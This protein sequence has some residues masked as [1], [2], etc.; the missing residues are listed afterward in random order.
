MNEYFPMVIKLKQFFATGKTLSVEFR[1]QQLLGLKQAILKNEENIYQALF[2]DLKKSKE[3]AWITEIGFV[4][5]EINVALKNLDHWAKSKK[6]STNLINLPS[7]SSVH[8]EPIGAVLVIAPWNYPFQLL[9][10]PLVGAIAAGNC[11]VLKPSELA[12]HTSAI[13]HKIIEA[14]FPKEY[15][16]LLEGEGHEVIPNLIHADLVDCVFF[17]GSSKIGKLVYTMAA[18]H[19]L[20]VTLELGGKS[21]CVIDASADIK[22]AAKRVAIA[23]FS[24]C[25]QMCVAPDYLLVHSSVKELFIKEIIHCIKLFF[26][27][28]DSNNYQYGKIINEKHFDRLV[29]F[30]K[31]GNVLHGGN[32]NRETL[33]F[34]PTVLDAVDLNSELMQEEI[35]GPILPIISYSADEEAMLLIKKH[36]NPL[37]FYIFSASS[38][39]QKT[40]L[41]NVPSGGACIN[42][43]SWHLT[44][45]NLPF[46]GRGFSG[47]GKY[48]GQFSFQTFS[49]FKAILKTPTWFDPAFKYPPF[50]G[51]LKWF[52][53][54]LG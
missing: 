31:S 10:A 37:A 23:K 15:V 13:M 27:E 29:G 50:K 48:H 52:K 21:P 34:E 46:G 8:S 45:P 19:L 47:I 43:A 6:V 2:S 11:C 14:A 35:F 12:P 1:K 42:N 51:K 39:S 4:L 16:L 49:H 54:I 17:T 44:N 53:K 9:F 7:S 33:Y 3:E 36:P 5:N 20:P 22:I 26:G 41:K 18:E 38:E 30:L 32:T 28:N 40:W 24:N 25:G